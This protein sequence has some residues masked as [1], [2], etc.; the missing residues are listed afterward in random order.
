[1]VTPW[2]GQVRRR[3]PAQADIAIF[4]NDNSVAYWNRALKSI[5]DF[6]RPITAIQEGDNDGN[7]R[8]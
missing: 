3:T 1:M 2:V 7:A 4:Y 8:T 5:A 6:W